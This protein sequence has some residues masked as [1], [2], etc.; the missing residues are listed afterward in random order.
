VASVGYTSV[1]HT[2]LVTI[3]SDVV[4]FFD[5]LERA[6]PLESIGGISQSQEQIAAVFADAIA[7]FA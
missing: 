5:L 6:V 3:D 4:S 2:S 7:T 1:V